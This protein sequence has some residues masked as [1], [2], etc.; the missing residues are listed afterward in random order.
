[1][2][3]A[4]VSTAA[5][6]FS[7]GLMGQSSCSGDGDDWTVDEGDCDDANPEVYPG[8]PELCDG[9]DN[10]CDGQADEDVADLPVWYPDTDGDG[11]GALDGLSVG[12]TGLEGYVDNDGDCDD[13][14]ADVHPGSP[15]AQ[16]G[17]DNDCDGT[18]DEMPS[19]GAPLVINEVDYDQMSD[20]I[21]EFVEIF[22]AY[23]TPL[24]LQNVSLVLI[25]GA[26]GLEYSR[27]DLSGVSTLE[28]GQYLVISTGS[29]V[30]N[31]P[32]IQL[33]FPNEEN[34]L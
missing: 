9:I 30:V 25:N 7:W 14:N 5:V 11:Y 6:L 28:D 24:S 8:A 33:V 17:I 18:V 27:F 12:C 1:V 16:D 3:S 19:A 31:P 10:D 34:N 4:D 29:V 23:E 32:A 13:A 26:N 15:E 21:G 22:N 20:D 2:L